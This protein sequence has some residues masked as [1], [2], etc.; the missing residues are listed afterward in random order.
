[1]KNK[2]RKPALLHILSLE[3]SVLDFE[4]IKEQLIKAG[5]TI[6]I[7]RVETK[8]EFINL[9]RSQTYELIL[10]DYNL[11]Q[12][13]AFEA[14]K[15]CQEYCP[16]TPFI[17]ISGAIGETRLIELLKNGATDYVMKDQLERLPLAIK[18]ALKEAKE[19]KDKKQAEQ[20]L[21]ISE[22][23]YRTI[24]ENVQDVFYQTDLKGIILE[25]SPSIKNFSNL[26]RNEIID[27]SV[28]ELYFN[29]DEREIFLKQIKE[30]GEIRDYE[31]KFKTD[32]GETRMISINARLIFNSE[33]QPDHIDGA[34]RDITNQKLAEETIMQSEA[35]LNYAQQIA[36]MGSWNYNLVTNKTKWSKN[37]YNILG[38]QSIDQEITYNDYL[39]YIHPDDRYLVDLNLEEMLKTKAGV[40][41][42]FRYILPGGEI[43]WVQNNII[44]VFKND[45]LIELHGVNIDI[46]EKKRTEHELIKAKENAEASDRLKTAFMNN[47]SHE[48]RTPLNGILGF[49]Q[50]LSNPE[51]PAEQKEKYYQMLNDSSDRLLNT[52]NNFMDI[53]LL[54][55]G[56]QKIE[57]KRTFLENLIDKVIEKFEEAC[58]AKDL[59]LMVKR[60]N[61]R[62]DYM[63]YTDGELLGKIL[64]QLID[65]A[66]KFTSHGHI[67]VGLKKGDNEFIFFV[68]D[69]GIGISEENKLRIFGHFDQVDNAD[70]R[71]YQGTGL[72]LPIAKGLTELLG[73]K[74]WL[75]SEKGKGS[76]F[77][78]S[79]PATTQSQNQPQ[80][81]FEKNY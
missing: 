43:M 10:A 44:P 14:L 13:D 77:Y 37:M 54:T 9:I 56:N 17:C 47:V 73:G 21:L 4:I 50:I 40:S 29:P 55:S 30:K 76:T 19:L 32:Q 71:Q 1:M 20:S 34:L 7:S 63:A 3:D 12:F 27:R 22:E 23:K 16:D 70:T 25:I 2:F 65:N 81:L 18:R 15:L 49:G 11:P 52:V 80:D 48:I 58:Q 72:G 46:T 38:H 51:F 41:F 35:E 53:S 66:V 68:K 28:Y 39:S 74:I 67:T 45:Q 61:P 36:K 26:T 8:D 5:Y 24:F 31:I 79:I 69:S 60:P 64:H 62:N 6:K 59:I 42:D 75:E 33:G 57:R 78:I